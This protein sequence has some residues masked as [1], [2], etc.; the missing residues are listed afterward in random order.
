MKVDFCVFF[1]HVVHRGGFYTLFI[2]C[3]NGVT[4]AYTEDGFCSPPVNV[5]TF[6]KYIAPFRY[7]VH[8]EEYIA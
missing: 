1:L 5:L 8:K 6:K 7:S 2:F 3:P 4:F